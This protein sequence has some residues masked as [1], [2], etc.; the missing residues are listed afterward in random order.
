MTCLCSTTERYDAVIVLSG[1][2]TSDGNPT[3]NVRTRLDT[4]VPYIGES[5][6][7]ILNSR[8]TPHKPPPM[9]PTGFPIDES[10]ASAE[11]LVSQHGVDPTKI[12]LDSWSKDTIGNAY[13]GLSSFIIPRNL[14]RVLVIT[15]QFHMDRSRII[16][17][18]I[19]SLSNKSLRLYY[20]ASPDVGLS[21]TALEA[22]IEKE[23]VSAENYERNIAPNVSDLM[24][25]NEFIFSVHDAYRYCPRRR[26]ISGDNEK[27]APILGTY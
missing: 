22:R 9:D 15:S 27:A 14:E 8:G 23:K 6:Y 2:L 16:F 12:L 21:P 19:F 26:D 20:C 25:L 24:K 13:F 3:E 18:H 17:D 4:A 11:Y 1:G 5:R 7:V 10:E